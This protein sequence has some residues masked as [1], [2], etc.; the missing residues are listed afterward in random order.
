MSRFAH[1][2]WPDESPGPRR[3]QYTRNVSPSPRRPGRK[4]TGVEPSD[5]SLAVVVTYQEYTV[6]SLRPRRV[7]VAVLV[8]D[9]S[10]KPRGPRG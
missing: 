6:V 10:L 9:A 7:A 5:R 2:S 1:S 4:T 3:L 8:D